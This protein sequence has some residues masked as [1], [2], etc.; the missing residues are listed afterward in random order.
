MRLDRCTCTHILEHHAPHRGPCLKPDCGCDGFDKPVVIV[1][2]I[3]FAP[4][5][6]RLD[7]RRRSGPRDQGYGQDH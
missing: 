5:G 7:R 1:Q 3:T 4:G 2:R 6:F